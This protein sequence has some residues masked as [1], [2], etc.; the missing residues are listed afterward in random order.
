[1]NVKRIRIHFRGHKK[2]KTEGEG[3]RETKDTYKGEGGRAG[4][5]WVEGIFLRGVPAKIRSV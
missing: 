5:Q 3:L 1:V 4:Q 2:K